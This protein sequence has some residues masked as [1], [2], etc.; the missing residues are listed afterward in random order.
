MAV[1]LAVALA[2][3]AQGRSGPM[4]ESQRVRHIASEIRCPTCRNQSA[5]D[6]DAAAAKAARDDIRRQVRAGR[7]DGQ[8][9]ATFV[10]RFGT[11]ILLKPEGSGVAALVWAL[12]VGA[13]IVALAGLA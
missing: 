3:G 6:S 2:I 9:L 11:D 5:A 4:T 10:G 13:V 12:P 7:S 8:I 1:V